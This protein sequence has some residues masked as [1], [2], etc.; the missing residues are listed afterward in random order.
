MNNT[1][2]IASACDQSVSQNTFM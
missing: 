1:I 2:F